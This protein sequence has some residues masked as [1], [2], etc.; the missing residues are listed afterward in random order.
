MGKCSLYVL[1]ILLPEG[2]TLMTMIAM[3]QEAVPARLPKPYRQPSGPW[4][5]ARRHYD[6]RITCD[7]AS[8]GPLRGSNRRGRRMSLRLSPIARS[9]YSREAAPPATLPL[10]KEGE[11]PGGSGRTG[12]RARINASET[13]FPLFENRE[14]PSPQSFGPHCHCRAC[15]GN[16]PQTQAHCRGTSR[17]WSN[18]AN[19]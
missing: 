3:E 7:T 13:L 4:Q 1:A 17:P 9:A 15:P 5:P 19:R 16:P 6:R 18:S 8:R 14:A 10:R 11:L 12:A 2:V